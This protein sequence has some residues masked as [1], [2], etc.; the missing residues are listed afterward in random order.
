MLTY[1][2]PDLQDFCRRDRLYLLLQFSQVYKKPLLLL[3]SFSFNSL[4]ATNKPKQFVHITPLLSIFLCVCPSSLSHPPLPPHLHSSI[5]QEARLS[6]K[7][8]CG[9]G[10]GCWCRGCFCH[11]SWL[12]QASLQSI[13][14]K[15]SSR[16]SGSVWVPH[17]LLLEQRWRT[18][19]PT[20][21]QA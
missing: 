1:K 19:T 14:R 5:T 6:W 16:H 7:Q 8:V 2:T 11:S 3:L 17:M 9:K 21:G 10:R 15:P 18:G 20:P 12:P 4:T 13:L